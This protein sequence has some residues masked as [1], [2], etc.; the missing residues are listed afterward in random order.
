MIDALFPEASFPKRGVWDGSSENRE[1]RNSNKQ[2]DW[3]D[4]AR[5]TSELAA[6][7]QTFYGVESPYSLPT[8]PAI[9]WTDDEETPITT[10]EQTWKVRVFGTKVVIDVYY[11]GPD[12]T[13]TNSNGAG[14]YVPWL[15]DHFPFDPTK[16]VDNDD[17]VVVTSGVTLLD[18]NHDKMYAYM[19]KWADGGHFPGIIMYGLSGGSFTFTVGTSYRMV[20]DFLPLY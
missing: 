17:Y 2:P 9:Y 7:Q 1:N 8:E 16:L 12:I 6:L 14:I 19:E 4:Y 3:R 13:V 20:F 10:V 11:N 15:Y 5:V 18:R